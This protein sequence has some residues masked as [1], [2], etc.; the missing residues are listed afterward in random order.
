M[1]QLAID[2]KAEYLK[3]TS[4]E[5][6]G[7][8]KMEASYRL[9]KPWEQIELARYVQDAVAIQAIEQLLVTK[10][11]RSPTTA[12]LSAA[13]GLTD[14]QLFRCLHCGSWAKDRMI[15]SNLRLVSW[16]A[17]QYQ[18]QGLQFQDLFQEGV[19]GLIR[20]VE[21]FDP[22]MGYSFSTYAYRWIRGMIKNA[23][24]KQSRL[25]RLPIY[26]EETISRI[27]KTTKLLFQEL[28]LDTPTESRTWD[29]SDRGTLTPSSHPI[30]TNQAEHIQLALSGSVGSQVQQATPLIS[31]WAYF[32][33]VSECPPVQH[34]DLAAQ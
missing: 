20:A 18:N 29:S 28:G 1:Q 24:A 26:V 34:L 13:A 9:L 15:C 17:K 33:P 32:Y 27:K 31:P 8:Q 6:T 3:K 4:S 14:L 10:L 5:K 19:F 12:E 11:G 16:I 2:E 7:F 22:S 23:I 25:I 30:Q 21:K